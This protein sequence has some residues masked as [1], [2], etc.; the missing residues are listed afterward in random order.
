MS[1]SVL[2]ILTAASSTAVRMTSVNFDQTADQF[3]LPIVYI[4]MCHLTSKPIHCFT[5]R[6]LFL[7]T[8][9]WLPVAGDKHIVA[10]PLGERV[11]GQSGEGSSS[12]WLYSGTCIKPLRKCI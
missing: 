3:Q 2:A 11:L 10:K 1:W 7:T 8:I 4:A 9:P 5:L 12:P 6:G